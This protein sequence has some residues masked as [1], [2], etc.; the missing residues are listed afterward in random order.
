MRL[1]LQILPVVLLLMIISASFSG[2]SNDNKVASKYYKEGIEAF[3][4]EEY[5]SSASNFSEAIKLN[6]NRGEYYIAYGD[7]LLM[8]EDYD[9]ALTIYSQ[10]IVDKN[11]KVVLE[12][13][14]KAY[15]GKGVAYY[16]TFEYEKAIQQFELSLEINELSDWNMDTLLYKGN[17]EM[18]AGLYE[19]GKATFTSIIEMDSSNP[20]LF[21]KR[22]NIYQ[23]LGDYK[24]S[25]EDYNKAITLDKQNYEYY[26]GKYF[27]LK[28]QEKDNE[29]VNV[30]EDVI[31]VKVD[32]SDDSFQLARAY[33]YMEEYEKASDSFN[34]IINDG[35]VDAH[36][37][38]GNIYENQ[39]DYEKAVHHYE[40]FV[41]ETSANN[42]AIAYNQLGFCL[43]KINEYE[44]AL[45]Y[46]DL[47]LELK[48]TSL[49]KALRRNKIIA[50][51]YLGNYS[52]AYTQL[53]EY[54][55]L[56][57]EDEEGINELEFVETRLPSSVIVMKE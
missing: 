2:C 17:A 21:Y 6:S 35:F 52:E 54:T 9:K 22:G 32:S 26:F 57:Q 28:E 29:A 51:E 36:F 18:Q 55:S 31:D 39:G 38:L 33:F 34:Q 24:N 56:Y 5:K 1:K 41:S 43:L 46:F 12:N 49:E 37:Y 7:A 42:A 19:D 40:V 53:E 11:N 30:L 45:T 27:L 50:L 10:A 16:K 47:G 8:L 48:D 20:E 25:L 44:K 23:A 4:Q 14:K 13:N 15:Y 3:E